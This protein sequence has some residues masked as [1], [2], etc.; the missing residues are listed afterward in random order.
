MSF[1]QRFGINKSI[2][3]PR[4]A[5]HIQRANDFNLA[6]EYFKG[7]QK[8]PFALSGPKSPDHN[9]LE[10]WYKSVIGLGVTFLIGSGVGI[11]SDNAAIDELWS[12]S[13]LDSLF[14]PALFQ[15][16][17]AQNGA[18]GGT[19]FV[20][21]HI[22]GAGDLSLENVSPA[23]VE[24]KPN[25]MDLA[26]IIEYCIYWQIDGGWYRDR[27]AR[28]DNGKWETIREEHAGGGGWRKIE[29]HPWEYNFP[30]IFYAKNMP[31][32]NS[33]YG[34]PDISGPGLSNTI[35]AIS[36]DVNKILYYH[37][38]PQM[39][40][41]GVNPKEVNSMAAGAGTMFTTT[42]PDAVVDMLEM[43]S[44]L[45]ANRNFRSDMISSMHHG[46]GSTYFDPTTLSGNE[47]GFAIRLKFTK[48]LST[49]AVKRVSFGSLFMRVSQA[50]AI[51][52]SGSEADDITINWPDALPKNL[53]EM[54]Q[55]ASTLNGIGVPL[56]E[57]LIAA[58][59]SAEQAEQ[60][61]E[62]EVIEVL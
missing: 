11:E 44:D 42:N 22:N 49:T 25:G 3:D 14:D 39:F 46:A 27:I 58:G 47:S 29:Q 13:G 41:R 2:G 20:R 19:A 36:S 50:V 33:V 52:K 10:D 9:V 38:H 8:K 28:L 5:E 15:I 45:I 51:I 48:L 37:S 4:S 23:S 12:P 6:W 1:L 32:A 56:Y 30:P 53:L 54:S 62:S 43:Q 7:K 60:M 16:E 59:F 61:S 55:V 17:L 35:N 34:L 57:S 31:L 24:M 26:D 18:L 40:A 21:L